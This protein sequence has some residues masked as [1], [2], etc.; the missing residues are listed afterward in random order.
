M[1][2]NSGPDWILPVE[3]H[4]RVDF[5][6]Q[7]GQK[8]QASFGEVSGIGWNFSTTSQKSDESTNIS[9]PVRLNYGNITL[10]RPL[11]PLS[12]SFAK[13]VNSCLSLMILPGNGDSWIKRKACDV[14]I[15][16][17]D[18]DGKP[19]A[20]WACYHAFPVKYTVGGFNAA[21]S[22][23]VMETVEIVYNRLE[24]VV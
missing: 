12:E 22:G 4:F 5:Q 14:I 7:N 2:D 3:F 13:W 24:R 15:K 11:A 19:L 8:F 20:G 16:L 9:L 17:L 6:N 23:L 18:K 10:K 1:P 21:N